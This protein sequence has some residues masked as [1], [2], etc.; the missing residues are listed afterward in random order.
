MERALISV[1]DKRGVVDLARGLVALGA[2][3]ISTGG[4]ARELA[5]AGVPVRQVSDLTGFPE[6]FDGRVKT[7][8]PLV[9]GG[10]LFRRDSPD[11]RRQAEAYGV[12]PIDLVCVN[13]Y[14]FEATAA[15]G[16]FRPEEVVE[17]IDVGGPALLRAAAKNAADVVVLTDPD[18]YGAVLAAL[19]RGGL[20]PEER[21]R[22]AAKAFAHTAYY[23]AVIAAWLGHRC[24][25]GPLDLPEELV[26]PFR[27]VGVLR[28]GENPHQRAALY[29]DPLLGRPSLASA[30]LL[31]GKELS[32]NNLQDADAAWRAV[33]EFDEPAAVAVKHATPCGVAVG[34][35]PL[36]AF[37]RCRD[38]DP[39]S[40]F[41]G[42][43]AFN[44]PVDGPVAE[45]MAPVFLEVV[46]APAFAPEAREVLARKRNLRLLQLP[47]PA[48]T[49]VPAAAFDLR[50]ID[51]GLLL[52]EADPPG[53]DDPAAWRCVTRAQPTP[54]D[55]AE[56]LFAWKV[57]KHA[58][59]N[60]IVVARAGQTLGIGAGEV[61]RVDAARM[62]LARAGA[63]ARGAYLASDAFFPFGDVVR[64]AAAA[65]IRAVVQPGGSVRDDESIA[66]ADAAG[67]V[68]LFTGRRHFRH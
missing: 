38:A 16:R 66:G 40:I 46:V 23:D 36:E 7:L 56:L 67:M 4:T 48:A 35:G 19:R 64:E 47:P 45:A 5:A 59:S 57:V 60:A 8:H 2:E 53:G 18:D 55:L 51:G 32:Y 44:R 24:G 27:R 25:A 21:L 15:A 54:E 10:I 11:H 52:Q 43:V 33:L 42:I 34:S 28:Y 50:R 14:P 6:L 61:N 1:S 3:V 30:E 65:G 39:V 12:R 29:R 20:A 9:H 68:M 49:A 41:G 22:L 13:L 26:L 17:Q 31:Q 62:A 58:R 37:H 63:R